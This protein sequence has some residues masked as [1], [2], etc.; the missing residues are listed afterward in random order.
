M[1]AEVLN[2]TN[3]AKKT[4]QNHYFRCI[5]L[6]DYNTSLVEGVYGDFYAKYYYY[7]SSDIKYIWIYIS[8]PRQIQSKKQIVEDT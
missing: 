2:K 1:Y 7:F 4:K 3:F 5:I 6:Y 8:I